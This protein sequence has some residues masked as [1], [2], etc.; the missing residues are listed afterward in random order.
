MA[1]EE[2]NVEIWSQISLVPQKNDHQNG[3][4][5][6]EQELPPGSK[7]GI[8]VMDHFHVVVHKANAAKDQSEGKH[9]EPAPL[10]VGQVPPGAHQDGDADGEDEHESAH[11]GGPLLG[12]VP[13]GAD[14]LDGLP[15]LQGP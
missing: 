14:L 9:I 13:G 10:L 6:L 1:L 12:H 11:G 7:A 15:C 8:L 3:C 5:E 2:R 4:R